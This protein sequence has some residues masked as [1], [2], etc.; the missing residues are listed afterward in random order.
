M[1]PTCFDD[2]AFFTNPR[3]LTTNVSPAGG[4]TITGYQHGQKLKGATTGYYYQKEPLRLLA[5]PASGYRFVK[6]AD[7]NGTELATT[8]E[9]SVLVPGADATVNAVFE[10]DNYVSLVLGKNIESAGE[11]SGGGSFQIGSSVTATATTNAGYRFVKWS[12]DAAGSDQLS[13]AASYTFILASTTTIYAIYAAG[14]QAPPACID[15][16]KI[17]DLWPL[18]NNNTVCGLHD[19]SG[20]VVSAVWPNGSFWIEE[21]SRHA[22]IR[23]QVSGSTYWYFDNS[24]KSAVAAGDVVDVYGSLACP[25]GADRVL[26]AS[27]VRDRTV[28]SGTAI[29]PLGISQR[30]IVGEGASANTPGLPSGRGVYNAGLLVRVAGAVVGTSGA[31]Y[32][33][34]DDRTYAAGSGI[35]I[36]SGGLPVPTSGTKVV[37]GVVGMVAGEPVIYAIGID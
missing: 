20:K 10:P 36:L 17:N 26:N 12:S 28:G 15:I 30:Y 16:A 4:G 18:S 14:P 3:L 25:L 34:L 31:D 35:R 27:Y 6:W 23:V 11:V 24:A 37:T 2:I 8:A 29:R 9:Y 19:A 7:G 32:F 21:T 1:S 22:G 13:T 5:T 33:F